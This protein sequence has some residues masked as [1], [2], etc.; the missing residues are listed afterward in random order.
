MSDHHTGHKRGNNHPN[1][2]IRGK[3]TPSDQHCHACH[4]CHGQSGVRL[5]A[6]PGLAESDEGVSEPL[7][8]VLT[9]KE[10]AAELRIGYSTMKEHLRSGEIPS[11]K[12]GNRRLI[13]GEDLAAWVRLQAMK[14]AA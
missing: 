7:P 14:G 2:G 1:R 3:H 4:A 10:A 11:F 13:A 8:L 12:L 5:H 9:V 6:E